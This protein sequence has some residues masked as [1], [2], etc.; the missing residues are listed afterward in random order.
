MSKFIYMGNTN[1][2]PPPTNNNVDLF[3]IFDS[4]NIYDDVDAIDFTDEKLLTLRDLEKNKHILFIGESHVGKSTII[5][6]ILNGGVTREDLTKP[7]VC[8]DSRV[9]DGCTCRVIDHYKY[10]H[11]LIDTIGFTD[12]RYTKEEIVDS[13][14][15]VLYNYWIGIS[16]VVVVMRHNVFTEELQKLVG[17]YETLLGS[18]FYERAMLI[19]TGFEEGPVTPREYMSYGHNKDYSLFLKKFNGRIAVGSFRLDTCLF[20]DE[21]LRSRRMLFLN[22]IMKVLYATTKNE[23]DLT[24][25]NTSGA[26]VNML[27]NFKRYLYSH[28]GGAQYSSDIEQMVN[29]FAFS[30]DIPEKPNIFFHKYPCD[31]CHKMIHAPKGDRD[32]NS[33]SNVIIVFA[34]GHIFHMGCLGVSFV[35]LDYDPKSSFLAGL[36]IRC[37]QNSPISSLPYFV[38]LDILQLFHSV[39]FRGKYKRSIE[40]VMGYTSCSES[41]AF[42]YLTK[43]GGCKIASI[44]E[45]ADVSYA[46]IEDEDDEV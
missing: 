39:H 22:V 38:V 3:K 42:Y 15:R 37:G 31:E 11:D 21:Y 12:P 25:K 23:N 30:G 26:F 24:L 1:T 14:Y 19:I 5:N 20:L 9:C 16:C 29:A 45:I 2:V 7:A 18:T 6:G 32:R 40:Y 43:Y 44:M 36:H 41:C 34:C 35:E 28:F 8:G 10:G 4:N 27:V 33:L 46:D 17:L 13:L